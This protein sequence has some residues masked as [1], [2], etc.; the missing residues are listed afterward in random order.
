M[1][2]KSQILKGQIFNEAKLSCV[3]KFNPIS[4]GS[5]LKGFSDWQLSYFLQ[6]RKSLSRSFFRRAASNLFG[7]ITSVKIA[8]EV[9]TCLP[10]PLPPPRLI[11]ITLYHLII[12]VKK[13]CRRHCRHQRRNECTLQFFFYFRIMRNAG[14]N[15]MPVNGV[16]VNKLA[17]V[18]SHVDPTAVIRGAIHQQSLSAEE[19]RR[20]ETVEAK[21]EQLQYYESNQWQQHQDQGFSSLASSSTTSSSSS[22]SSTSS[23]RKTKFQQMKQ[24]SLKKLSSWK[25]Q[26]SSLT[27]GGS[28]KSTHTQT[29]INDLYNVS[30]APDGSGAK[31]GGVLPRIRASKSMQN[32]EQITRD[33]YYNLRD[34]STNLKQKYNSRLELRQAKPATQYDELWDE[35]DSDYDDEMSGHTYEQLRKENHRRKVLEMVGL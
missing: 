29:T 19:R 2:A 28:R 33:S 26:F 7:V 31:T 27:S 21:W 14:K 4:R 30:T 23:E 22:A 5:R 20:N 10:L 11:F 6:Q 17:D 12:K 13:G 15:Y 24:Q 25:S 9:I 35:D 18:V 1:R 3:T 16:A 8:V 32:L 34:I